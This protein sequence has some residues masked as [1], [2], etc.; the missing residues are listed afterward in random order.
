MSGK[1]KEH[2]LAADVATTTENLI[3]RFGTTSAYGADNPLTPAQ[4]RCA[5][6]QKEREKGSICSGLS[7]TIMGGKRKSG[8][9]RKTRRKRKTRYGRKKQRGNK[10]KSKKTRR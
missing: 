10:R 9:R 3:K 4:I 7:C 5:K 6:R 2:F 1:K 8:R